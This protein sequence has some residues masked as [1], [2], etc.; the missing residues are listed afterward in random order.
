MRS[1]LSR[2]ADVAARVSLFPCALQ[3]L[4][5]SAVA[6]LQAERDT[7][8][9]RVATL[10]RERAQSAELARR[11][12]N[13]GASSAS[14]APPASPSAGGSSGSWLPWAS[15][16]RA[17]APPEAALQAVQHHLV[18]VT[19]DRDL[20]AADLYR[21][22]LECG[23]AQRER[24]ATLAALRDAAAQLARLA[25]GGAD[26]TLPDAGAG[27]GGAAAAADAADAGKAA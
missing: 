16:V 1:V 22:M 17:S 18:T 23:T 26:L 24:D 4:L 21:C 14:G 3:L 11:A 25:A 12:P 13:S 27:A 9:A 8:A 5:R 2:L 20:L 7:L 6:S 19:T 15:L 10:E